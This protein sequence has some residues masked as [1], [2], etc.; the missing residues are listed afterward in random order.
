[1]AIEIVPRVNPPTPSPAF[2]K[3]MKN[4]AGNIFLA[5]QSA[6]YISGIRLSDGVLVTML[7]LDTMT[8]YALPVTIQNKA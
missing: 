6:G 4:N 7:P 2:P 8:D 5:F 3:L 1:M